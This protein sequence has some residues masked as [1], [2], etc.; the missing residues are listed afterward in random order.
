MLEP[1]NSAYRIYRT[2]GKSL[3]GP[4]NVNDLFNVGGKEFTGDP[5]CW[6]DSSTQTW[7]ATILFINDASTAAST[8]IARSTRPE[9]PLGQWIEYSDRRARDPRRAGV[10]GC[11]C[12]GDQPRM[13]IDQTNVYITADEFSILGPEFN[14]SEMWAVDKSDLVH[15]V[16]SPHLVHFPHLTAATSAPQPALSQGTPNAEYMLSS[17]D[18]TG[19]GDHRIGVWAVTKRNQVGMGGTPKPTRVLI[20]LRS[21]PSPRRLRKRAPRPSWTPEMTG[22]SRPSSSEAPSGLSWARQ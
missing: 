8:L 4:F 21:T 6:F 18:P 2:T 17:L 9:P 5:R 20:A 14:G 7:F 3:R 16:A 10:S 13:G 11:P 15:G 19:K 1:V 22:C 12:F